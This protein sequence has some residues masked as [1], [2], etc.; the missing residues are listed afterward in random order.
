MNYELLIINYELGVHN[1][2]ITNSMVLVTENLALSNVV[3]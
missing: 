1:S 3:A 2:L